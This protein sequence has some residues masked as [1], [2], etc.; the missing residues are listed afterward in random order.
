MIDKAILTADKQQLVL[1]SQWS[2]SEKV[3]PIERRLVSNLTAR[4]YAGPGGQ[5]WHAIIRLL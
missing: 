5:S 4:V 1:L 3:A 2:F